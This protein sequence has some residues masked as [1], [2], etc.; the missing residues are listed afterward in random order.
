M[1][2]LM[3]VVVHAMARWIGAGVPA[4]SFSSQAFSS[5]AAWCAMRDVVV[6]LSSVPGFPGD[7]DILFGAV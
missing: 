1:A 5:Q 2:T 7:V 4:T 3:C 6:N